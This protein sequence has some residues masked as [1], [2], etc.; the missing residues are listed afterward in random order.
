[1]IN[2]KIFISKN[3]HLFFIILANCQVMRDSKIRCTP[4]YRHIYPKLNPKITIFFLTFEITALFHF[5]LATFLEIAG[6]MK[7]RNNIFLWTN[8]KIRKIRHF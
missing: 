1:M 2:D 4:L 8:L 7:H 3:S 6:N 5:N